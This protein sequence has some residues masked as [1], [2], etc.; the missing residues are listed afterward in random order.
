MSFHNQE[1]LQGWGRQISLAFL[2]WGPLIKTTE[3][4]SGYSHPR[5]A[6]PP[7]ISLL[8]IYKHQ[9]MD[10]LAWV[11]GGSQASAEI[12]LLLMLHYGYLGFRVCTPP[13][14]Q[15]IWEINACW[16]LTERRERSWCTSHCSSFAF[17]VSARS[18]GWQKGRRMRMQWFLLKAVIHHLQLGDLE[19][20]GALFSIL[21]WLWRWN[22]MAF[23][24]CAVI[25]KARCYC[26]LFWDTVLHEQEC[27]CGRAGS[28]PCTAHAPY[29]W[30]QGWPREPTWETLC[31]LSL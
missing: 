25:F 29:L 13:P 10:C 14:G 9:G 30:R 19:P 18:C 11:R 4:H 26:L 8:H 5:A 24:N 1:R 12:R 20:C 3:S 27:L 16:I 7:N 15:N 28:V 17:L 31:C 21:R 23:E 6:L 22:T 2:H